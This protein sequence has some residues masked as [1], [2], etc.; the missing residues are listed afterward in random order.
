VLQSLRL[1]LRNTIT[2]QHTIKESAKLVGLSESYFQYLYKSLFE[3][4]YQ[5]DIIQMRI[6]YA[7]YI[8]TTTNIPIERIADICGYTNEVHFY[9]QFKK[10][11]GSTPSKYRRTIN[12]AAH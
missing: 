1:H 7:K 12:K 2:D 8:I 4:S 10:S 5:Q 11:T 9:R 3:I 6:D